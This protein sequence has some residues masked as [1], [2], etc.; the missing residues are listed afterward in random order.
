[1]LKMNKKDLE[2]RVAEYREIYGDKPLFYT[3]DGNVFLDKNAAVDHA[4]KT[5]QKWFENTVKVEE[6]KAPTGTSK[7]VA[8]KILK[9][10]ELT[11]DTDEAVC[12][13]LVLA[14]GLTPASESKD[15]LLVALEEYKNTLKK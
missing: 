14:L 3:E 6:P 15:D 5:N 4:N 9:E 2:K 12:K 13:D 11:D 7:K 1:M 10:L 8:E